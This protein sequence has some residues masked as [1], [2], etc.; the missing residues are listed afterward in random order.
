VRQRLEQV[1]SVSKVLDRESVGGRLAFD[2]E[3]L[4]GSDV[5]P[6]VARTVVQAGWSLLELKSSTTLEEVFLEL[7]SADQ[8]VE[9][10]PVTAGE[11]Q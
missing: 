9:P 1:A 11:A 4:A 3:S 2:V 8:T 5:R 7:T 10:E 6:D